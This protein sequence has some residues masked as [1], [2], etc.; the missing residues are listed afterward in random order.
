MIRRIFTGYSAAAVD[1][2]GERDLPGA[3]THEA[4][5]GVVIG[6]LERVMPSTTRRP[7]LPRLSLVAAGIDEAAL[8]DAV[9]RI[10]GRYGMRF[11]AEWIAAINT[12]GDLVDCV[13]ERMFDAADRS[14]DDD[15]SGYESGDEAMP[16]RAAAPPVAEDPFPEFAALEARLAGLQ[17]AGLT[18]PFL[19]ANERVNGRTARIAGQEV[20]TFTSFDYLGLAGHPDV[21][22]AAKEAID[23]FGTSA[24]ASRMVG[25]NST[26]L[27]ELDVELAAFIGTE[28][29]KWEK[30]V[31]EAQIKLD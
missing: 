26:L 28:T 10:E 4:I 2:G 17:E 15:E 9:A 13:A 22:R 23:R 18:N 31:I 1:E 14:E 21:T 27:D 16:E 7:L 30:L 3:H 8:G 12:C 6:E 24:S 25:G 20:V 19:L 29:V 5:A 11:H